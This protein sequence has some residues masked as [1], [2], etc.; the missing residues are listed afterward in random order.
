MNRRACLFALFL[1]LATPALARVGGGQHY[2]GSHSSSSSGSRSSGG[3]WSSG[4]S[5]SWSGG[6]GSSSSGS[7]LGLLLFFF[8]HPLFT[9]ALLGVAF[10]VWR[11][12]ARNFGATASTQ[13]A[14]EAAD[15]RAP[16][17][18][19]AREVT[20]WVDAL[21]ASDPGF[22]LVAFLDQ[23]KALFL[24][25]QAAWA[26]GELGPV[27][28]DLSD[29]T[30][31][32][33]RVQLELLRSQA[34]RNVTADMAV[35]D[36]QPVGLE[37]TSAFD[38][39]HVRIRAQARDV[40]LPVTLPPDAA[41]DRARRAPLEPFT[42][43]W[44]FVRRPGTRSRK[45][46]VLAPGKCPNCG[47]PFDGGAAGNC[48]YCGAIVNSGA[49]DWVLAEITQGI[50][51]GSAPVEVPGLEALRAADP[52]LSLEV[53]EDRASLLFWGWIDA[54]SLG[55]PGRMA[56]LATADF[57]AE[58]SAEMAALRAR[59]RTRV[60]LQAA[61]GSVV[62]RGIEDGAPTTLAQVEIRWSARMG[63]VPQ[64]TAPG[65][66]ATLP[67]RW[68]F[69]LAR[70]AGVKT[71]AARGM[72]TAR[73][74]NCGAPLGDSV[75]PTCE[76]CGAVLNDGAH[77]WVL[78]RAEPFEVWAARPRAQATPHVPV[79]AAAAR[80][81]VLDAAERQRLLYTMA[82]MAAADGTVDDRERRMLKL[83]AERWGVPYENVELALNA[84][85]ALFERLVPTPG[86]GG[87]SFLRSLVQ[88]ALVDGKV[89]RQER[90]MLE[91]AAARLGLTQRLPE[92]LARFGIG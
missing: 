83:C 38:T 84:D 34:V 79:P 91:A 45:D 49:Y 26:A 35:L 56:K 68:I 90:R 82:A 80:D 6:G 51:A 17:P 53:L 92:L 76:H 78:A 9:L 52:A 27:R 28:S 41:M 36:L 39:F 55:E 43:V 65:S 89:D 15:A 31:Q 30:F 54:Q 88:M 19:S 13:R 59:Q 24:R 22:D 66:L 14:F 12:Y 1:T 71:D 46:A 25:V 74:G 10:V 16:A 5:S 81:T 57:L 18:P 77:D 73:C 87:E 2:S 23:V 7:D 58:L 70:R 86:P 47:A 42:E 72:A 69:T 11:A 20:S 60:F 50:E 63:V 85:P 21:H 44:S 64:G 37:R 62:V 29:A 32:R 61:V 40:D 4:G 3:S 48:T 67:Q 8:S 75:Q 33:F